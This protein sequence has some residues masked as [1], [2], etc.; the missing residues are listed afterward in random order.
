MPIRDIP[1]IG[2]AILRSASRRDAAL[3]RLLAAGLVA[4]GTGAV[5]ALGVD[6]AKTQ[7][8]RANAE[9]PAKTRMDTGFVGHANGCETLRMTTPAACEFASIRKSSQWGQSQAQQ[10][11]SQDSQHSQDSQAGSPQTMKLDPH[12]DKVAL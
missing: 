8:P 11:F 12:D 5:R 10:G 4:V 9:N 1:R 7:T 2:P 6:Q 3:D